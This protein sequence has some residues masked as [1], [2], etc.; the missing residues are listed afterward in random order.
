MERTQGQSGPDSSP[1]RCIESAYRFTNGHNYLLEIAFW[2]QTC[3]CTV[4]THNRLRISIHSRGSKALSGGE[5]RA[6]ARHIVCFV[7]VQVHGQVGLRRYN[8]GFSR[9]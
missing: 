5:Q 3:R 2:Q 6:T 4:T 7:D 9:G 1:V 8:I